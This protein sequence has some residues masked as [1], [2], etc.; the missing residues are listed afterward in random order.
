MDEN[1]SY[2]SKKT[3]LLNNKNDNNFLI[4]LSNIELKFH[5]VKLLNEIKESFKE[6]C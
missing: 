3:E 5:K 1:H 4:V 2:K 6:K